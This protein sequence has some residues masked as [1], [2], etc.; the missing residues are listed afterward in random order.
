ME[1]YAVRITTIYGDI[2]YESIGKGQSAEAQ[3]AHLYT[4][5]ELAK[6]KVEYYN[7]KPQWYEYAEIVTV[8]VTGL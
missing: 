4:K 3:E 8:N 7:S 5:I 6:K 1:R 2:L